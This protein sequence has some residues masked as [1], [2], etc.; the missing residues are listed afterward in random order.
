MTQN[1]K[2]KLTPWFSG[3]VKPAHVGVYERSDARGV[4]WYSGWNGAWWGAFD[5][6]IER[7]GL[8]MNGPRSLHQD[9]RW[10]GLA[11][12]PKACDK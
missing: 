9:W 3:D 7:A 1:S 2:L 4:T 12:Q 5:G 6:S 8:W 11:E 10:R